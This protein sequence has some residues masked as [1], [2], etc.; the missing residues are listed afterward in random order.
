MSD[1]SGKSKDHFARWRR[2]TSA[3]IGLGRS[4]QAIPTRPMLEF[5]LAHARARDAV[6]SVLDTGRLANAIEGDV[7]QAHSAAPDRTTYLQ[8]PGLG[9]MLSKGTQLP[10]I[11]CELAIVLADG[12]SATAIQRHGARIANELRHLLPDWQQAPAVIV[13]QGRVAIGDE[14]GSRLGADLVIV[15][16][17]ERP[18]LSAADSVGAYLTWKPRPGRSDS[19][20]NCVS[21]IRTPGGLAPE[22]G[23]AN[24]A[25]LARQAR[26]LKL[27]GVGLKDRFADHLTLTAT[28][29][30][31]PKI[32]RDPS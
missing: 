15:L 30:Q 1:Q 2:V 16:I 32:E 11:T 5:Q 8:N 7:F 10:E 27:T 21:N 23:A 9:R 6:H 4:G 13:Q 18:G 20:R 25:W 24:I 12:L 29:G 26:D 22:L 28:P 17:G 14:I 3:R 19:E 31:M